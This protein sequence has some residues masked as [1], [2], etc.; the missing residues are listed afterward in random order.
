M[1]Y[2]FMHVLLLGEDFRNMI[3]DNIVQIF[4]VDSFGFIF[5][6]TTELRPEQQRIFSSEETD[7][8]AHSNHTLR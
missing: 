3:C 2:S 5:L 4:Y 8:N 7:V 6:R 1:L